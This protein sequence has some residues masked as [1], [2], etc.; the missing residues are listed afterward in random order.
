MPATSVQHVSYLSDFIL[1]SLNVIWCNVLS[2]VGANEETSKW[3][4]SVF[5]RR[6][7]QGNIG[8]KLKWWSSPKT[9]VLWEVESFVDAF[10][11][12]DLEN[13][14]SLERLVE[15][16]RDDL[17]LNNTRHS[18]G[19]CDRM[20]DIER[21]YKVYDRESQG[22]INENKGAIYG[23]NRDDNLNHKMMKNNMCTNNQIYPKVSHSLRKEHNSGKCKP[24]L[25]FS[26]M[27]LKKNKWTGFRRRRLS[28][29]MSARQKQHA[30]VDGLIWNTMSD[31]DDD[32]TG[33]VIGNNYT[34]T[35]SRPI[36]K[37]S[38]QRE[39][40]D[41]SDIWRFPSSEEIEFI[42]DHD[43]NQDIV[44]ALE[45]TNTESHDV[46]V[47]SH[48]NSIEPYDSEVDGSNI[49]INMTLKGCP[50]ENCKVAD[51][52]LNRRHAM[53]TKRKTTVIFQPEL[54]NFIKKI[55]DA[56][57]KAIIID[58]TPVSICKP[59]TRTKIMGTDISQRTRMTTPRRGVG[60]SR[61]SDMLEYLEPLKFDVSLKPRT[62]PPNPLETIQ[63]SLGL[64]KVL[65]S[66]D[67][68]ADEIEDISSSEGIFYSLESG[69]NKMV[70]T[71]EWLISTM[72][73]NQA[74]WEKKPTYVRSLRNPSH[75]S[76]LNV[77]KKRRGNS[78]YLT[79]KAA[80]RYYKLLTLTES[81]I[82]ISGLK[83]EKEKL[84]RKFEWKQKTL[85]DVVKIAR[86][87]YS[88]PT[89]V[90]L[91]RWKTLKKEISTDHDSHTDVRMHVSSIPDYWPLF[92]FMIITL[93]F[94]YLMVLSF[95][96]GINL[97]GVGTRK[98]IRV[99][100]PTFLGIETYSR[101][102]EPNP[103]LGPN[104]EIFYA[105]GAVLAPCMRD[106]LRLYHSTQIKGYKVMNEK[107]SGYFGCCERKTR[108][109][110]VAGTST[111]TECINM[112]NELGHWSRGVVYFTLTVTIA[113]R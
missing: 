109:L 77:E 73:D 53:L 45:E 34:I 63:R 78:L 52:L 66:S 62:G 84:L 48:Y 112:T 33:D 19:S 22:D 21:I 111:L 98:F 36:K 16:A 25:S 86:D 41:N 95:K 75:I 101:L 5:E 58:D 93:Q 12:H 13:K 28:W 37:P 31:D 6:I 46:D 69:R 97:R 59:V 72:K 61:C 88:D 3:W 29:P 90:N 20:P 96:N 100:V 10:S 99:N 83:D 35:N 106:D 79:G 30:M 60:P 39:H 27:H 15:V 50:I 47:N 89:E 14:A 7:L 103:W 1:H 56:I 85:L 54:S 87:Y 92:S 49:S 104:V 74:K 17:S 43:R 71:N 76:M 67:Q 105:A 110:N 9:D 65:L 82:K 68:P 57:R 51:C 26:E 80:Y 108:L 18:H 38:R 24:K 55:N 42:D 107:N 64:E 91:H 4:K 2:Y 44:E 32:D 40:F 11:Q 8:V 102:E 70:A 94:C 113:C 81:K 23:E